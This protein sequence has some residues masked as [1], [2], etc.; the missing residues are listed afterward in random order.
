M[1]F[2]ENAQEVD[3][4]VGGALRLA[5]SHP[6]IGPRLASASTVLKLTVHNPDCEFTV[7]LFE[8][9]RVEFG[10][11]RSRPDVT[12][13]ISGDVLDAYWRGEYDLLDGLARD[14]VS[15]S[16][17]VSRVL[18]VL[19]AVEGLFP[20]Y[21]AMV[22][23][24]QRRHAAVEVAHDR[25]FPKRLAAVTEQGEPE[26]P[27][28]V[29]IVGAGHGGAN[30]AAILRQYGF[31]GDLVVLGS[32]HEMPY[33][34]PPLSKEFLKEGLAAEDL[35]IKPEEF[36][37]EQNID[38]R[39]GVTV[40]GIDRD[41]KMV[42]LHDQPD[43]AYDALVLATGA[44]ARRLQVPGV[45]LPNV[46]ELRTRGDAT[47]IAERVGPGTRLVIIG[48]GYVGLEVAASARHLGAEVTVL[49]RE[50]R[51]LGRVASVELADWLTTHHMRQGTQIHT[52]A[53]VAAFRAGA[54][55]S[56][57]VVVLADGRE[58]PCDVALVGVGALPSDALARSAG[59]ACDHG[60]VVDGS[61][62]TSDPAIY[63]VGDVTRRPLY[64]YD[65]AFR[66]ES[67]PSAVEQAKQAAC[68]IVGRERPKPEV[69]WFWSDQFDLKVKIAG[70]L[71]DVQQSIVRG[72][73]DDSRFAVYHCRDGRVVAVESVNS[74]SDF[75]ASKQLIDRATVVDL[76]KLRDPAVSIRDVAV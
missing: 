65:G 32:E 60:I 42:V 41:H 16:G 15:A 74:G 31:K 23:I 56:V 33:Q 14:E 72:L 64:H 24:K 76:D 69:P 12:L 51:V 17:P 3:Q 53:D 26:V 55:G 58:F 9:V 19:P 1:P 48:G 4:Y 71:V 59:L 25:G 47:F 11:S 46:C 8:P 28:R 70:I 34:R 27:R 13:G 43:I 57:A 30:V 68:A 44:E 2:F 35:L 39:L 45:D 40:A 62:R 50:S 37:A 36:Y 75:M 38:L 7:D 20:A 49:E 54:E 63:A 29:V 18:K 52:S 22:A 21:R 6:R 67:I 73:P 5:A 10:S 61:A 66:L